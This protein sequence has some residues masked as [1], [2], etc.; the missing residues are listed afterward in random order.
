MLVEDNQSSYPKTRCPL[1]REQVCMGASCPAWTLK[2][3]K[4]HYYWDEMKKQEDEAYLHI[5]IEQYSRVIKCSALNA[6]L[7]V[8]PIVKDVDYWDTPLTNRIISGQYIH[9]SPTTARKEE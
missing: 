9:S 8:I 2:K 7:H 6:T 1:T 5:C 3:D 4:T